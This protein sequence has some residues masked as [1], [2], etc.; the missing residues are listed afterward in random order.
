MQYIG[1]TGSLSSGKLGGLV[2][3]RGRSGSQLRARI[4]PRQALTASSSEARAITGGLPALWRLLTPA[5]HQSWAELAGD[6][7]VRDGYHGR[8]RR[9]RRR[10]RGAAALVCHRADADVGGRDD[11][12]R[13]LRVPDDD[14][15]DELDG[16]HLPTSARRKPR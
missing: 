6:V 9:A 14:E 13:R 10:C 1:L 2:G 16:L 12:L 15:Y 8:P 11:N 4:V 3:S 5:E 7:P